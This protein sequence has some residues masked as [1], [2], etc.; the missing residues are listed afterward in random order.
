MYVCTVPL[1]LNL[2]LSSIYLCVLTPFYQT[3]SGSLHARLGLSALVHGLSVLVY[4][5]M[6]SLYVST[7]IHTMS[8]FASLSYAPLELLDTRV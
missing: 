1:N 3:L 7:R 6:S 2:L 8:L 5:F 4:H